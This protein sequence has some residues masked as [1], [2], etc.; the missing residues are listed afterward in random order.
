M[1]VTVEQCKKI[2]KAYLQN[3]GRGGFMTGTVASTSP[4]A[5]TAGSKLEIS[6][7]NT[8][9]TDNC[10]GLKVNGVELRPPLKAGDGV[11]ILCRPDNSGGVK[12]IVLD[13]IQPYKAVREV[14]L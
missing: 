3:S 1:F 7:A 11:L 4:L 2:I 12:Y 5:I 8:Y 14:T 9:V 10:I 6:A 13:R